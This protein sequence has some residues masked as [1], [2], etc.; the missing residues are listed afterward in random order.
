MNSDVT[1][2]V[3]KISRTENSPG[4]P[5]KLTTSLAFVWLLFPLVDAH[6]VPYGKYFLSSLQEPDRE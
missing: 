5:G 6:A 1:F 3:Q 2:P 4:T